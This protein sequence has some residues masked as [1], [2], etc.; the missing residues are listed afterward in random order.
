[1]APSTTRRPSWR[2][3]TPVLAVAVLGRAAGPNSQ[4]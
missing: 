4:E 2:T 1:M 3:V